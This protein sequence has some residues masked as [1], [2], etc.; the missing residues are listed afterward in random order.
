MSEQGVPNLDSMDD[1]D[2]LHLAANAFTQLHRYVILR[3]QA[4]HFRKMGKV[5]MAAEVERIME[6]TYNQLPDWAR[7]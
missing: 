3:L 4:L 2:E 1:P 7:W 5:A 6:D